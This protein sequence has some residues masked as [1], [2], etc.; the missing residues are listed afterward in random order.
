MKRKWIS[1]SLPFFTFVYSIWCENRWK[2]ASKLF[3]MLASDLIFCEMI[4]S[5]YRC[6]KIFVLYFVS[7]LIFFPSFS[8]CLKIFT[9]C[10]KFLFCINSREM[11]H[12]HFVYLSKEKSLS[13]C[14][15]YLQSFY[16]SFASQL[17]PF[18]STH[19]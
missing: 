10:L 7:N 17:P 8:I 11:R 12:K 18:L 6:H 15:F 5:F 9:C 3:S 14:T 19:L 13:C 2:D 1:P 16:V 4:I